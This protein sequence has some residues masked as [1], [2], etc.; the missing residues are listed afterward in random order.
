MARVTRDDVARHAGVSV[1]VVSYVVNNGPRPVSADKRARVESAIHALGYRRDEVAA[2]LS[3]RRSH[4]IGLLLPDAAHPYFADIARRIE[5]V[6]FALGYIVL[7][8][9]AADDRA[10]EARHLAT[11]IA[12]R[13]AG[14]IAILAD[15]ASDLPV[16]IEQLRD[17]IVL[18]DRIPHGWT[19]NAVAVDNRHGGRLAADRLLKKGRRKFLIVS[20][21]PGFAHMNERV[22]GFL[23]TLPESC[24]A[25][26][27]NTPGFTFQ[28]GATAIAE[29]L[30]S[31]DPDG[32]FCCSD[33]LA[34]GALAG[35]ARMGRRVPD[36]V[37]VIGYDD[38][39]Q[40]ALTV[41]SLTSV[42]Q[43]TQAMAEQAV[44]LLL[45]QGAP[46]PPRLE[47]TLTERESG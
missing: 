14:V 20:G 15:L 30:A 12:H 35:L 3:S 4:I 7:V 43:P 17:R 10:R 13:V 28:A 2:S 6:A 27:C 33:T 39:A 41:P 16:E 32:V 34:I 44:S 24:E 9:N 47:P 45:N 5:D 46:C 8:G 42:A 37:A 21:P 38:V 23:E 25:R 19:G 31:F 22:D 18:L 29:S 26:V 40:S 11:F 36:D 1:A